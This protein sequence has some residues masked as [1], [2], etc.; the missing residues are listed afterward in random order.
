MDGKE[1]ITTQ[2]RIIELGKIADSLDLDAFLK[3]I[4]NAETI[5]PMVDPTLFMKAQENMRAIKRL[6]Q[7]C[8]VVKETYWETFRAIMETQMRGD[9]S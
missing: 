9:N 1:Y 2:M 4:A 6:A 3:C 5:A 8:V 7:A